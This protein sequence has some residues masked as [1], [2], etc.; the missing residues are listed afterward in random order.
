MSLYNPLG[1]D[2]QGTRYPNHVGPIRGLFGMENDTIVERRVR[3]NDNGL[4][5]DG[6]AGPGG[7]VT[8]DSPSHLGRMRLSKSVKM[9]PP[10]AWMLPARP[11]RYLSG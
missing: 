1:M 2:P 5:G 4:R 10:P 8:R 9:W 7:Y 6:G 3:G 11:V